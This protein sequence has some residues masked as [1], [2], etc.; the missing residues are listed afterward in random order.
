MVEP[1]DT[2]DSNSGAA[3]RGGSNPPVRT[4]A[5]QWLYDWNESIFA[6]ARRKREAKFD[7]L[8]AQHEDRRV[9]ED[10][11]TLF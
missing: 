3:R 5:A 7:D 6:E 4:D 1:A 10:M 11:P 2:P 9:V 8:L